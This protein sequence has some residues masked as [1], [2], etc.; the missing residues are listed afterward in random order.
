MATESS[1]KCS[2]C[3][4]ENAAL[5]TEC[6]VCKQPKPSS[7]S[8][9]SSKSI[10]GSVVSRDREHLTAVH[11]LATVALV[12]GLF[13]LFTTSPM[14]A[15][16]LRNFQVGLVMDFSTTSFERLSESWSGLGAL[17]LI[18]G[19][20]MG[21]SDDGGLFGAAIGAFLGALVYAAICFVCALFW[22]Y[23]AP[24][25]V[26][27]GAYVILGAL[28]LAIALGC[29]VAIVNYIKKLILYINP[30]PATPGEYDDGVRT[31][32]QD[33][34]KRREE[35]AQ[36]RS[37]F[38]GPGFFSIR[39]TIKNTWIA[40]F[41]L[42]GNVKDWLSYHTGGLEWLYWIPGVP[43]FI[44]YIVAICLIGSI[45]TI[46]C[47]LLHAIPTLLVMIVIYVLFSITWII[48]RIYL[49]IHSVKTS[50]PYD[51]VRSVIPMFECP[52][53][54]N[55]HARLV[56]GPY[57]IW[58]RRCSCGK[59]LPTTF[60]LGRSA[61]KAFCPVCGNELAASD[62]QQFSLSVVGGTS[63]GKTVLLTA[64][65]HN[66]LEALDKNKQVYY[67]IPEIH[68]DMFDNM[69]A[70]Y[71]GAPCDAT[72]LSDTSDMYSIILNSSAFDV[73]KQFSLYDIAGEAFEDPTMAR[74]LPQKQLRDSNGIV[75]V[76]DPLSAG[77][78]RRNAE[79]EGDD[80]SNFS[81]AEASTIIA[82]FVTYLNSVLTNSKITTRSQKP[83]AVVITKSDLASVSREISYHRIKTLMNQNPGMFENFAHA[84]NE[85]SRNFLRDIGLHDAVAAIE[86]NFTN[87]HYFPVSAIG[88]AVNG[89]GYDP[90]HVD[91]PFNWLIS[92]TEPALAEILDIQNPNS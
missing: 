4:Y 74:M 39:E 52:Q 10:R 89:E 77:D 65:Y 75:I 15:R 86:A 1:W 87:V 85:I 92:E 78:M 57:G 3:G 42:I 47:S 51:Q 30:Y 26:N 54:G 27:V 58:H 17:L 79:A 80:T 48:D 16:Y 19:A 6:L 25:F 70:W 34:G 69:K 61:L 41:Q 7:S 46:I 59:K 5:D 38:F 22:N 62:V 71:N 49:H 84:R 21:L 11:Y 14:G 43:F 68:K 88:H 53:C 37:Y 33:K 83:V 31:Y 67:D 32:Y 40:N 91:E 8:A 2:S 72:R 82:N 29:A 64:F 76:I 73:R 12:V 35:Y 63:S 55:K 36:H 66:F 28:C 56:P 50:C 45:V 18:A 81:G 60:L 9:S 20:I 13:V 90:E 24:L 44:F 23:V